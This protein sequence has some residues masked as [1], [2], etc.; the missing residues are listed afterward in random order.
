[1]KETISVL[2]TIYNEPLSWVK[3]CID[4]ILIQRHNDFN[5]EVIVVIDNPKLD[6]QLQLNEYIYDIIQNNHICIKT[7]QNECN[8]GLAESLNRAF[9]ESSGEYIARIDTDDN[10]LPERFIKQLNY[11]K[12]HDYISIVGGH[13]IRVDEKGNKIGCAKNTI[14][15]LD[16]GKKIYYKSVC[17]HPTWLMKRGVFEAL[18]GYR[19]YPNS[20]DFDF[21]IR[22]YEA[23]YLISNIDAYVINYR[24]RAGSLSFLQSLRQRKC[25]EH[26][27]KMAKIRSNSNGLDNYTI[28]SMQREIDSSEVYKFF[29]SYSQACFYR[30]MIMMK[31]KNILFP[32]YLIL[33]VSLSPVQFRYV[34]RQVMYYIKSKIS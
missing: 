13:V 12:E 5:L 21:L 4:S 20:Q 34:Y 10:C 31:N 11:L 22:A 24:I 17:Y 25:Q 3:E 29:H 7:I 2:T 32:L 6:Y 14:S 16:I 18:N 1:M 26:I 28:E 19:A 8:V 23:G 30:S 33:S 15:H 9:K 27:I